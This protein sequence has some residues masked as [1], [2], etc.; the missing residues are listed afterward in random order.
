VVLADGT[1]AVVK[2][3]EGTA[4]VAL[5]EEGERLLAA[6]HPGV[7]EVL[8]SSGDGHQWELCL[9]HGGRPAT[10]LRAASPEQVAA[11]I[12]EAA[13]TLADLHERGIVHGRLQARHLLVGPAGAVRLCG[14]GPEAA[15]AL[16]ADDVAALGAVLVELLGDHEVVEPLPDQ[17]WRRRR[18]WPGV[19]RRSLL[20]VADLASAEPASRRPSA[21]RLAA[22]ITEAVPG[23]RPRTEA[24][25]P[26]P[27]LGPAAAA[28]IRPATPRHRRP[29]G[30]A[31]K[32]RWAPLLAAS[33]GVVLLVVASERILPGGPPPPAR[34]ANAGVSGPP[35]AVVDPAAGCQP[36]VIDGTS[37]RVGTARFQV[38]QQGDQIIAFD[39]DCDGSPTP[40]VLRPSTGEVFLF[41]AWAVA[42]RLEVAAVAVVPEAQA[43]HPPSGACGPPVVERSDGTSFP[44]PEGATT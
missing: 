20:A 16:P 1:A 5:Q 31:P 35:C 29:T 32:R 6:Q 9:A 42:G 34:R 44:I 38:G 2:T 4:R 22:I 27:H 21:R 8:R 15:G 26:L 11:I 36:I 12:A 25:A 28:S 23:A 30:H 3:A 17:R 18:P 37:V 40:A 13:A 24:A 43:I 7:V 33:A 19:A 39:W 41:P 14:F 10:L